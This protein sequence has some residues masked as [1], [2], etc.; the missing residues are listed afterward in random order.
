MQCDE[1]LFGTPKAEDCYQPM[2]RISY[3]DRSPKDPA[4]AKAL[5]GFAELQYLSP[6]FRPVMNPYASKANVQLRRFGNMIGRFAC[7]VI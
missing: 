4:H 7:S 2:F 5:R 1:D 6:R 3:I